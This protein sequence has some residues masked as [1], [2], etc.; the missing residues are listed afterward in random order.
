MQ[1][2]IHT[3]DVAADIQAQ[4][5]ALI[6][7]QEAAKPEAAPVAAKRTPRTP[8]AAKPAK[9]GKAAKEAQ[10]GKEASKPASKGRTTRKAPTMAFIVKGGAR[11]GQGANLYAFTK[12]W[13]ECTGMADGAAIPRSMA[14]KI[15]GATM[16]GYHLKQGNLDLSDKGLILTSM[17][18]ALLV[19]GA[20]ETKRRTIDPATVDAWKGIFS[21]GKPDGNLIKNPDSLSKV[22]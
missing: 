19:N 9:D 16:V 3:A 4:A 21:T 6:A 18:K 20:C 7:K 12:A 11:P 8:Q 14:E 1:N 2:L 22:A 13:L 15:A 10:A 5:D 17:G